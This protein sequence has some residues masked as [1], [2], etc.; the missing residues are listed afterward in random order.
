V[1]TVKLAPMFVDSRSRRRS[2]PARHGILRLRVSRV[3]KSKRIERATEYEIARLRMKE[4]ANALR[5]MTM[6]AMRKIVELMT[7]ISARG[8]LI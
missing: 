4:G 6:A 7:H 3:C 2:I 5:G 1:A 8:A